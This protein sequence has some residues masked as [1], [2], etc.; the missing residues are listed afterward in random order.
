[1]ISLL[2][3]IGGLAEAGQRALGNR[4]ILFNPLNRKAKEIVN[5]I[6]KWMVLRRLDIKGT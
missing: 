5:K 1:M 6:K 4:S 3:S 2:Q